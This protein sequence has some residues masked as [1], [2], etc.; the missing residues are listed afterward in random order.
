MAGKNL[1]LLGCIKIFFVDSCM[2]SIKRFHVHERRQCMLSGTQTLELS[3][4]LS[5]PS[6][7]PL[8]LSNSERC[9]VYSQY[10]LYLKVKLSLLL[11]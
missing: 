11:F 6:I 10:I 4:N 5:M 2:I 1:F 3:V 8:K 9:I 7:S